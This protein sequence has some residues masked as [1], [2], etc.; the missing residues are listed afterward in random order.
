MQSSNLCT[1]REQ[2][3]ALLWMVTY[4]YS[5]LEFFRMRSLTVIS[6]LRIFLFLIQCAL[7]EKYK[8][9]PLLL[10]ILGNNRPFQAKKPLT[11]QT[12]AVD[13]TFFNELFDNLTWQCPRDSYFEKY[14]CY[15][16]LRKTLIWSQESPFSL[17]GSLTL[18]CFEACKIYFDIP[19]LWNIL[20]E[21]WFFDKAI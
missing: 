19:F 15:L 5:T 10:S 20:S 13:L 14:F 3:L 18:F 2:S 12:A 21:S 4:Y 7:K 17:W 6:L 16:N 1:G 8:E 11:L 9:N